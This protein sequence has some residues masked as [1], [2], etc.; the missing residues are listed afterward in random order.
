MTKATPKV[1]DDRFMRAHKS[2]PPPLTGRAGGSRTPS[3]LQQALRDLPS[4]T[5]IIVDPARCSGDDAKAKLKSLRTA[6]AGANSWAKKNRR[7]KKVR[8]RIASGGG[9]AAEGDMLAICEADS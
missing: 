3:P 6:A 5:W 9:G 8:V 2:D 4:G 7:G 1:T